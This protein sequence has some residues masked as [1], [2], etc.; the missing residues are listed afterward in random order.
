MTDTSG[1]A[2]EDVELVRRLFESTNRRD[3]ADVMA[4]YG[5]D[6]VLKL[7]DIDAAA[8]P[9]GALGKDAVGTW[10]GDWF[11]TFGTEYHFE[12]HDVIDLGA[13]QV[14]VDA[15]HNVRGRTA[16]VPVS[17]RAGWLYLVRAGEIVRCDAYPSPE[18]AKAAA[19]LKT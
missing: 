12:V 17:A 6:V 15:T 2:Q 10:F 5:D 4:C 1:V 14:L 3:F 13:G 7:Q 19:G 9:P 16:G 11:H 8:L 18:A